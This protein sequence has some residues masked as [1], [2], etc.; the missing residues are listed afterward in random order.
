MARTV[1]RKEIYKKLLL[2]FIKD[3]GMENNP[4]SNEILEEFS[5][6]KDNNVVY[7]VEIDPKKNDITT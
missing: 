6:E 7:E 4:Y 1:H 5:N 2:L 3:I